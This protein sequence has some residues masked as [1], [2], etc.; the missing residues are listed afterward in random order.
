V[1]ELGMLSPPEA[2]RRPTV[3]SLHGDERVDDWY[4]LRDR[5]DPETT[6]YLEAENAYTVAMT[7]HTEALQGELYEEIRGRIQETDESAAVPHGGHW[8]FR[9]TVEGLQ[10]PT[11]CRRTG[12]EDAPTQVLLDENELAE[13][14]DYFRLGALAVSPDHARLAYS[15]DVTG[16]ERYTLRF[17]DLAS[18]QDLPDEIPN[19]YY[20]VAWSSDSQTVFYTRPDESMRPHQVWR[21]VLGTDPAGDVCA[22]E[23]P[24]ERFFLSVH[25]TRSG[26]FIVLSVESMITSEVRVLDASNAE[27][28]FRV[29]EP[30][31]QGIEYSVDHHG[32]RFL[33]VTNDEAPNFRLMEAPVDSPGREHWRELVPHRDDV[34]L[35]GVDAFARHLALYERAEALQRVRVVDPETAEGEPLEQ[36]EPVYVA[37][38][39]ENRE[40]ETSVLR[41]EYT[42]LVTPPSVVDYDVRSGVRELRKQEPVL[43]YEPELYATERTWATAPDGERVPLSLVYRRDRPERAGPALLVGYGSY[44]ASSDPVFSSPRVSLLDRGFLVA[45]AHVR[46]GGEL[47]RRWYEQGKLEQKRNT[48]TDF[49]ACAEHLVA[50]GWTS[51]DNLAARGGSAGGLLMGAAVNMRPDLFGAVV[52]EVPFVDVVTTILDESLPLTVIEWEEWGNPNDERLY[53]TMKAYSPYDNV[54]AKD[55]PPMLVTAGL[56]DSRVAYWEPAK[57]VAKL[58]ATKTDSNPLL[59]RTRMSAGHGGPSGRYERWGEEA[60]VYAFLLDALGVVAERQLHGNAA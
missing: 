55:Y 59:L 50:E 20:G 28:A 15:T 12:A 49:V 31:R 42:S 14:H 35:L 29:V 33:I 57:W 6:A 13:G 37:F 44:E 1:T 51:P 39:G 38:P 2:P 21:H 9:R 18:G 60:F 4:W 48:F 27:G 8:Y 43:G 26:A 7:A 53:R 40:F 46:G 5:D 45:I 3:M 10:Y 36:P 11:H 22:H 23:E 24:D 32:G 52:A 30:R 16:A 25:R 41:F 54:E 58:R 17:R 56:H 34:R 47:G 19:T